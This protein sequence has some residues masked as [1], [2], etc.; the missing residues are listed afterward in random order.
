MAIRSDNLLKTGIIF[1]LDGTLWDS[2]QQVIPAWNTVLSKHNIKNINAN[3]M[4]GYMGKTLENI[5]KLM[6]PDL[7]FDEAMKLLNEC[8]LEEQTYL[9]QHGGTLYPDLEVTLQKLNEN[10]KLYI[11]SNCHNEY[12]ESFFI[13]HNLKK[14]FEDYE[15]HGNTGLSK[16]ENIKLIID[17]N[18]LDRAVYVGDTEL[19][20]T[21]ALT[22]GI[23]FIFADY[24]FGK[25]DNTDYNISKIS[26]LT[27]YI[28]KVF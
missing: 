14:Y 17:R 20:M 5:S 27:D 21:S 4:A 19:D 22:A 18:N 1:D 6:L 23:P 12:L 24:G 16:A 28:S 3:D 11:V 8:C 2:S 13:A 10:Y 9:R 26:D 25:I 15:T 7:P